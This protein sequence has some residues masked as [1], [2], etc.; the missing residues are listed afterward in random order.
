MRFLVASL[1]IAP[2]L[3]LSCITDETGDFA[4]CCTCLEQRS[5]NGDGDA[6]DPT[7]N[8][9]PDDT[10]V[11]GCNEQAADQIVDPQNAPDIQVVD[12]NCTETTCLDECRGAVLRGARFTVE[13][14]SLTD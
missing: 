9:L 1:L 7:T 10:E 4:L 6:I 5:P 2:A 8:C 3:S 11:D 12:E 13:Q 14:Q